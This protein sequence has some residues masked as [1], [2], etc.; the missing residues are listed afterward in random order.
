MVDQS[1][2]SRIQKLMSLT[3]ERGASEAE[4]ALAAS[5]VQRLLA[6]NNLSMAAI[7]ASGGSTGEGGARTK[8]TISHKQVYKWQ[9][10]LM[11]TVA[12][13]N[14]CVA[15]QQMK[16]Q[17]SLYG[18]KT[19]T[20]E[21][22]TLI[23]RVD[24][25][26][27]TKIMF[28][29]L[30]QTIERLLRD[31]VKD[32]TQYFT[33][34]AHSFKEGC[35]DRLIERL[36]KQQEEIVEEQARQARE[37]DARNRHPASARSN[38]PAIILSDVVQRERDLNEDMRLGLEPGTTAR[39]NAEWEARQAVARARREA[40]IARRKAEIIKA[41]PGTRAD[42]AEMLAEGYSR[43]FAEEYLGIRAP[44]PQKPETE[45]QRRKREQQEFNQR[46]REWRRQERE[47][48]RLDPHGYSR[49]HAAG[50][51]VS[52]NRQVDKNEGKKL[53]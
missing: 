46:D 2:I 30:V 21:G 5:H 23:G 38:L 7:E 45:A 36:N 53:T 28:E 50:E 22:Y 34:Y 26:A 4:A 40:G 49:G 25:V 16:H 15:L 44:K 11:Q 10:T 12:E 37:A 19:R 41:E 51:N 33:R 35:S 43:E 9:R 24:N 48:R 52:L 6:D 20:F 42:L 27:T 31:H 13:V 32:P 17:G 29:Y 47:A 14:M 3:V 39:K 8:E 18:S 1:L